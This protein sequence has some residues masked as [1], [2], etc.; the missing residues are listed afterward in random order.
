[1]LGLS[2]DLLEVR[3]KVV[4][5]EFKQ[6]YL[7]QPYGDVWLRLRPLLSPA[8]LGQNTTLCV[9]AFFYKFYIPNNASVVAQCWRKSV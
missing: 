5:E 7:N 8:P 2:F 3:Q 1:M 6:R 4:V 9:R